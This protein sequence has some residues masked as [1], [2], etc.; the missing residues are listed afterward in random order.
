MVKDECNNCRGTGY[1]CCSA[2]AKQR[3]VT[4]V[5][6]TSYHGNSRNGGP[7]RQQSATEGQTR[8]QRDRNNWGQFESREKFLEMHF[9]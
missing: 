2:S 7:P 9:C 8:G 5:N 3:A 4:G 6:N 1:S